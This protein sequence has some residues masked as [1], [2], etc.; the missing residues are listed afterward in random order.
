[1]RFSDVD[2]PVAHRHA[3][4]DFLPFVVIAL[5]QVSPMLDWY[6]ACSAF[7][8]FRFG[9]ESQVHPSRQRYYWH[10]GGS[11]GIFVMTQWAIIQNPVHLLKVADRHVLE[12]ELGLLDTLGQ[13]ISILIHIVEIVLQVASQSVL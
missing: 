5:H 12:I 1:M 11:A 10:Y 13:F 7:A 4:S 8:D 6:E 9:G 3:Y 2:D